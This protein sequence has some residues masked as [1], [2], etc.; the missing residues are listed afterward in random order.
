MFA[1]I[2]EQRTRHKVEPALSEAQMGFRKGRGCTDAIFAL[3]Q[4]SEKAI[5]YN[6][7]LN[8]VFVDQEKAFDRV[9]REKL[10]TV[11]EQYNVNGQL[12]DNIRALYKNC[13]CAVRTPNGLTDWFEVR[14]GVRQGCVL[15]PLLFIIYMDKITKQA[16]PK[17][18]VL[19]EL[20]F[21]DD[22]SLISEKTDRLQEHTTNLNTACEDYDMR[23]SI[24]KTESLKISRTPGNLD[25]VINNRGL[26]Q[27]KEFKYLGSIFTED[28]K[29]DREIETRVQKANSVSY[30]L[31]PLLKHPS[32]PM[33]TK[34]K[35]FNS[36][37]LPTL[38]YQCQTWTLTKPLERKIITCEMR[39]LRRLVNRTRRDKIR[40][41][42]IRQMAG[43]RPVRE[44]IDKQ[45]IKWFGHL[46]RM[47]PQSVPH[48]AYTSR[49]SGP[50]A[51]GRPRKKWIDSVK[52]TLNRHGLS[53]TTASRLA[54]S[55]QLYLP[56]TPQT[57]EVDG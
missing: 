5:E 39:C 9:N 35:L 20:L 38:T 29:L 10:W 30:Q 56:T 26:K 47:Q 51:R 13:M 19:N 42:T 34:A 14:S 28:G 25:I 21:A 45:Q 17:P 7:E 43:V 57:V 23:I 48:R 11:L 16:N 12:L 24:N 2:L 50:K 31:A 15:S 22:Q 18:E 55:R 49:K 53:S 1:K 6:K 4:L 40:N 27:V 3:R 52:D 32:I 33:E 44:F 37:F 54:V 36:I 41:T 8:L 46:V